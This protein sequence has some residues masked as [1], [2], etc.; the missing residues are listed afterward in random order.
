M[1]KFAYQ[2]N[3]VKMACQMSD[4]AA[5]IRSKRDDKFETVL[6]VFKEISPPTQKNKNKH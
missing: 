2:V 5:K 1:R 6:S 3:V 4:N